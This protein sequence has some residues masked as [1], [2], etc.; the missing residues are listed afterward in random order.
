MVVTV[1]ISIFVMLIFFGKHTDL[2]PFELSH[3]FFNEIYSAIAFVHLLYYNR[4]YSKQA[5]PNAAISNRLCH[6]VFAV[7]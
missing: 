1:V 7:Y 3:A 4:V 5:V 2:L 6:S